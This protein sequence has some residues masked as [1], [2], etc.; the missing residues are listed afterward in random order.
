MTR[1]VSDL[2]GLKPVGPVFLVDLFPGLHLELMT[3]LRGLQR[4]DWSRPTACA[5]WSVKDIVAHLLDSCLRRLSYGRDRRE[6]TPDRS[7]AGYADLVAYLNHLNAEWVAAA[8]RLSPRL[9]MDL[10]DWAE[11]QLHQHL[12]SLDP[13]LTAVFGVAWAGEEQSPT[14]FDIGREYTERWLHQQQIREAVGAPGLTSR[15]WLS[16]ALDIFVRALPFSYREVV[17]DPHMR[18]ELR[19]GGEAGGS[20]T[21]APS[22]GSWRLF[23][24]AVPDPTTLVSLDQDTAWKLFSKALSPAQAR[25]EIRI[26]GDSKLGEPI[27]RTL[28]VMA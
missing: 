3:L 15:Q 2:S 14:W 10:L 19:I 8:R 18:V 6:A 17:A 24:G 16:P 13:H 11:P 22:P 23:V 9:L 12:E 21:L 25:R 5:L 28:A 20:W 1:P 7:I 4:G 27:L 26:V